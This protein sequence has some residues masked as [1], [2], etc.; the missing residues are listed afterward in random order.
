LNRTENNCKWKKFI[1]NSTDLGSLK[2]S[3]K[4]GK[5]LTLDAGSTIYR[6][7]L[8]DTFINIGYHLHSV[9]QWALTLDK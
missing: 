9:M 3:I 1:T 6:T 5:I 4:W 2:L 8:D 7:L